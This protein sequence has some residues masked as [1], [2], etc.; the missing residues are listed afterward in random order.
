MLTCSLEVICP[1]CIFLINPACLV[2]EPSL[3]DNMITSHIHSRWA[4]SIEKAA[5]SLSL[6]SQ[7]YKAYIDSKAK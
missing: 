7:A 3:L 4:G 5:E 6:L 1:M 2:Q